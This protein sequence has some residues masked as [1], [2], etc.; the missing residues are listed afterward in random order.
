MSSILTNTAA[1]AAL[2][3]L[4][5]IGGAMAD[6]QQ[7]VSSGL[8]VQTASDNAA[9]WSIST[10]MRSDNKAISAVADALGLAAAKI[11]VAYTAVDTVIGV[12]SEF[13]AKLIAA[14]EPGVDAA[15]IQGELEQLKGQLVSVSKSAS[16]NGVNWL[17]TDIANIN[18][19]DLNKVS[20]TSSFIR[21]ADGVSIGKTDF[22]LSEIALFNR[23]GGGLLQADTRKMLT[24]GGIRN[25]DTYMDAQGLIHMDTT[26]TASGDRAVKDFNFTGPLTFGAS[27]TISF[28]ITVDA[29]NPADLDP[30]HNPGKTTNI[31]I[32]RAMVDTL[33]PAANGVISSY[34]Q[35]ASLLNHALVQA[36]SGARA[37]TYFD[38]NGVPIPNRIGIQTQE[39]S[40]LDGSSVEISG[41]ASTVGSGGMSDSLHYGVRGSGMS[42]AFTPFEVYPDGDNLD[43]VE[44]RFSFSV[45]GAP[46]TDHV[47]DRTYVNS[48][49][50]KTNGKIETSD[51]MVTLLQSLISTDWPDVIIEAT[52]PSAISVRS[53]KAVD[54]LSGSRTSIGFTGIKVSIEP[55]AEQNLVDIDIVANP[56]KLDM[57]IGYLEVVSADV[58]DA[59]ATLGALKTRIDLQEGFAQTL[60][61]TIDKGVG[62]LVDADMNEASTRL[63]ALQAQE[64]LAIQSLQIANSNAGNILQLFR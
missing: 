55:L 8:R 28:S 27:D 23:T 61:D 17:E 39:N 2:Q 30:P 44:M 62:R 21:S 52:S 35:Y 48:L 33:F 34:T 45:N 36:N 3:T 1:M 53:D 22:H 10:T 6:T 16:F 13:K 43:G 32:D 60:M 38:N 41:F 40:G 5:T 37:T 18:D 54:R 19:S 25:Y 42:L 49:L 24:L 4:R 9:Y 50:S 15:K 14:K 31:I 57:Y 51:E 56:Q 47:F 20:L 11:D 12:L 64:Q 59:G 7:Q 26:N 58:I 63:K 46:S 29:D